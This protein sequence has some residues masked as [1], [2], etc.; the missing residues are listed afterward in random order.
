MVAYFL[1]YSKYCKYSRDFIKNL[2]N[3]PEINFNFKKICVDKSNAGVLR[4][5]IKQAI[6]T[7]KIVGVP[8]IVVN[9]NVLLGSKAEQW[10]YNQVET[11]GRVGPVHSS[12]TKRDYSK[13]MKQPNMQGNSQVFGPLSE[14]SGEFQGQTFGMQS[15]LDGMPLNDNTGNN[16]NNMRKPMDLPPELM[17]VKCSE[18]G[19]RS[20]EINNVLENYEKMRQ[21]Q[22]EQMHY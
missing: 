17:A 9:G 4:N 13:D 19:G 8:S 22:M 10:L 1:F 18:K 7:Y 20:N 12:L 6:S 16:N 5:D 14:D 15:G 3:Y 2:E 21:S 11:G